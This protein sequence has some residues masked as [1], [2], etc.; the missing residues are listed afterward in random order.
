[1]FGRTSKVISLQ[2]IQGVSCVC[3]YI[4]LR[5]L[6]SKTIRRFCSVT[7]MVHVS[8]PYVTSGLIVDLHICSLLAELRSLFGR[9]KVDVLKHKP[10]TKS[11]FSPQIPYGLAWDLTWSSTARSWRQP[12]VP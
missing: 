2:I 9:R 7:V 4:F 8:H 11:L 3:P 1:M 10:V 6:L 12:P 5:N